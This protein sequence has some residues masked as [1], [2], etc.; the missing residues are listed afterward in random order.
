MDW[1]SPSSLPE[2]LPIESS[3]DPFPGERPPFP[4]CTGFLSQIH[5]CTVIAKCNI[6]I[7]NS[8]ICQEEFLN[9]LFVHFV[10]DF[11]SDSPYIVAA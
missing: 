8:D 4:A 7:A 10:A 1:P 6:N 2:Q 9:F 5:L 3:R 11:S